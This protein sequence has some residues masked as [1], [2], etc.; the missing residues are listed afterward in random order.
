M[1]SLRIF[2]SATIL[3]TAL[4]ALV[5]AGVANPQDAYTASTQ[6]TTIFQPT[7]PA[8]L[9]LNSGGLGVC[10]ATRRTYLKW[11]LVG[12]N[13]AAG[14]ATS[15][16]LYV[17]NAQGT[18]TGLI[19]LY[20]VNDDTW[21]ENTINWNNA[22]AFGAS[23][24]TVPNPTTPGG[25]LVFSGSALSDWINENTSYVGP[26]DT[27]AGDDIVSFGIEITDCTGFSNP[28]RLDSKDKVGGNAPVLAI[29]NP[30]GVIVRELVA[31]RSSSFNPAPLAVAALL[32][33]AVV[34]LSVV[35]RRRTAN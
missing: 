23:I 5:Y 24:A 8:N 27:T 3:L 35:R 17:N 34:A 13:Q 33:G 7:D 31:T 29:Y 25:T 14:P 18:N 2:L 30:N 21:N 12:I 10:N 1:K 28:T 4:V 11:D 16:T 9:E 22:P 32:L 6:P 20:R 26:G 19:R 15:L